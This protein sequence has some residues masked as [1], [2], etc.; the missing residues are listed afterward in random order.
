MSLPGCFSDG[1]PPSYLVL[2]DLHL[3]QLYLSILLPLLHLAQ[4]I[5]LGLHLLLLPAHLQ[6]GLD[7]GERDSSEDKGSCT[8]VFPGGLAESTSIV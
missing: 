5:V 6:Q 1:G 8:P 7:L 2:F 4:L 3:L